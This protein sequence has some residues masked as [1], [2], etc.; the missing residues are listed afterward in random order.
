MKAGYILSLALFVFES[1]I[2]G[3]CLI[4][5]YRLSGGDCADASARRREYIWPPRMAEMPLNVGNIF[6]HVGSAKKSLFWK[7]AAASALGYLFLRFSFYRTTANKKVPQS[8]SAFEWR[9]VT[10]SYLTLIQVAMG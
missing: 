9:L 8:V 2:E 4:A 5:I 10:F 3:P 6:G 1:E 7:L